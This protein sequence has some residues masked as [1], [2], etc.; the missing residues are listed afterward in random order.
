MGNV[1][2]VRGGDGEKRCTDRGFAPNISPIV[3]TPVDN[4]HVK[5]EPGEQRDGRVR[6]VGVELGAVANPISLDTSLSMVFI[7]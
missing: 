5:Q 6:P 3:V 7:F 1:A 4:S 2:S